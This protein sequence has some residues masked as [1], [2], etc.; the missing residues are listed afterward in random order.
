[1]CATIDQRFEIPG[2]LPRIRLDHVNDPHRKESSIECISISSMKPIIPILIVTCF[3]GRTLSAADENQVDF[4]HQIVPIL[5]QHCMECHGGKKSK[6]GFSMN[7]RRLFLEDE[8]AIPGNALESYFLELIEDP[9]PEYRMPQDDNPPVPEEEVALLKRWVDQ[10]M[11]WEPGFTF[12]E[13]AYEPPLRPRMP[14]LPKA[15]NGRDHPIDR[16]IDAYLTANDVPRPKPIDDAAFLRRVSLDLVGL[17]PTPE[18]TRAFLADRSRDKRDRLIDDLL[19]RD[20][21]YTEHW[22]TFW[23]DLLRNDYDGTGFITGGRTQISTWLYDSLKAN[24]PFDTMVRELIAPPSET[25][26]GFINGS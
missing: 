9:D 10:G 15:V 20:I 2:S 6:G 24:K 5:K 1:V 22:L 18:Q 16:L 23:N 17:L 21:D 13:P 14:A 25:S 4:S 19:A 11:D 26:A 8:A 12:G 7:T 3:L